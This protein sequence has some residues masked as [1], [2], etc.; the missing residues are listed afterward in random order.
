MIKTRKLPSGSWNARVYIGVVDGK[1]VSRSFTASTKSEAQRMAASF[2]LSQKAAAKEELLTRRIPTLSEAMADFVQTCRAQ[3]YSPSTVRGYNS[4]AKNAFS[5]LSE[6]KVSQITAADIQKCID[7]RSLIRSVKT[8]RNEFFFLESVLKLH[9]PDLRLDRI[10]MAKRKKPK[11]RIFSRSWAQEILA[12]ARQDPEFYIYISF[13]L[14]ASLRPSEAYALTWADVSAEPMTSIGSGGQPF[15]FGEISVTKAAVLDEYH[16]Y[17]EKGTKSE[18]GERVVP[19]AWA[20]FADL[21]SIRPRG[22]DD[23]R[24]LQMPPKLISYRWRR[25]RHRLG[26]PEDFRF[27]DLRHFFA[28]AM[29]ASGATEEELQSAMGHSTASFTHQV[30]VE[31]FEEARRTVSEKMAAETARLYAEPR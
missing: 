25:L 26:L 3:G 17:R 5:D 21:Y 1:K 22:S 10:T 6:I 28:T 2:E 29:V 7:A 11:K 9:A 12:E 31:M 4:I 14:S 18:A 20:F 15:Q 8:V 23:D 24:I 19:V 30:Y 27:Y 16:R 13:I